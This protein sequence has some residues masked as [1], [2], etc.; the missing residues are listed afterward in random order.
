MRQGLP[1]PDPSSRRRAREISALDWS[2]RGLAALPDFGG[3][4]HH[5]RH[6]RRLN[7][8]G[9]ALLKLTGLE[10][11][12][13]LESLDVRRNRLVRLDL[14]QNVRL[15]HLDASDN[16]LMAIAGLGAC[17]HLAHLSLARNCISRLEG[18][19]A[20]R[21]LETLD[22]SHNAC[23]IL[24]DLSACARLARLDLSHNAIA[25]LAGAARRLP[26]SLA[27]LDLG[28][29][30]LVDV[31]D[32]RHLAAAPALA[33]LVLRGNPL[34]AVSAAAGFDPK[35]VVAFALPRLAALDGE[36]ASTAAWAARGRTL[37]TNDAGAPCPDLLALL[38]EGASAGLHAYL[39]SAAPARGP[40]R[41]RGT[42]RGGGGETTGG[43]VPGLS[44]SGGDLA[45]GGSVFST[46][47]FVPVDG[48]WSPRPSRRRAPERRRGGRGRGRD[49]SGGDSAGESRSAFS[50]ERA[51]A[52]E[53]R[54]AK[55]SADALSPSP[56]RCGCGSRGRARGEGAPE[57][58]RDAARADAR[59][60]P[61]DSGG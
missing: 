17:H 56:T 25:T 2:R 6:L 51:A 32:A 55:A 11:M 61:P 27:C 48:L 34:Y 29:N 39:A 10:H 19:D 21:R 13:L 9:N 52:A 35:A 1:P 46:S 7:L 33:V 42:A 31:A 24:G 58:A 14:Q 38:D 12:P 20:Q 41:A 50:A 36:G 26:A 45:G 23:E 15:L 44:L 18:L 30:E 22:V 54:A 37:F 43:G 16:S 60:P 59:P 53:A 4:A 5:A 47:T 8:S 49:D 3:V 57:G 40:G 28:D